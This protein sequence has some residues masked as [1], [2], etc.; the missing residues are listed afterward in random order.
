M[1]QLFTQ[2]EGHWAVVGW[3]KSSNKVV[4]VR[5]T[6]SS[7]IYAI[8]IFTGTSKGDTDYMHE[9]EALSVLTDSQ[10]VL[11]H[12]ESGARGAIQSL[13]KSSSLRKSLPYE[14]RNG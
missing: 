1:E 9:I 7:K 4:F 5:N 2:E 14:M 10:Y 6:V 11:K 8:K 13:N 3:T 12:L